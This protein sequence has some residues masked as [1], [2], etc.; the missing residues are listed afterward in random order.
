MTKSALQ[1]QFLNTK[2]LEIKYLKIGEVA[3]KSNLPIKTIRYY[4][5]I[6]LLKPS[7]KRSPSNSYRLFDESVFN[8]LAFIKR[9]QSLGLSLQEIK[10]ILIVRDT[11]KIPCGI[12]KQLLTQKLETINQQIEDL[13]ILKSEL[14]QILIGWKPVSSIE[15]QDPTIC[16]NIQSH[17]Q[18][19]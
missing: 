12:A 19:S 13:G 9:S 11:G 10:E 6:G 8:R 4:E 7:V 17:I 3:K 14:Q 2:S 18:S 15:K 16:P 5:E 1:N